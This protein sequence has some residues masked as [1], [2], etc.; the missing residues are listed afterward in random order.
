MNIGSKDCEMEENELI[1]TP[2]T[3]L[4]DFQY[5]KN[6]ADFFLRMCICIMI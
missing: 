5:G 6:G 3:E 4:T 2:L 1:L